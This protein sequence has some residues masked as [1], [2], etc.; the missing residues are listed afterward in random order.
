MIRL[1]L[2]VALVAAVAGGEPVVMLN[3]GTE[4]SEVPQSKHL[5]AG[6]DR[7]PSTPRS[8]A[9]PL[10][11]TP[12]SLP[13][14]IAE[15]P[16]LELARQLVAEKWGVPM[17]TVVVQPVPPVA[18]ASR[19]LDPR[20][21]SLVGSGEQNAEL[22]LV[23]R[24]AAPGTPPVRF[25]AGTRTRALLA[26]RTL[27]RGDTLTGMD[28][29]ARDTV[30]WGKPIGG[31][32]AARVPAVGWIARRTIAAGERLAE[33]AVMPAPAVSSGDPVRAIYRDGSLAL[34]L[35]GVAGNTAEV[36]QRVTVRI[37]M[38]R[39]LDG[40]AVAPGVVALR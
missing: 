8:A 17:A 13:T 6:L 31:T 33:P 24:S 40:I 4:R 36:G 11:M 38:R 35:R 22:L 3:E 26:T 23:D 5:D 1:A 10:R 28:L 14:D 29:L 39:R 12:D 18:N 7:G 30:L 21:I 15:S 20:F 9:A 32:S 19:E 25:R 27:A 2:G 34:A 37:D 16:T